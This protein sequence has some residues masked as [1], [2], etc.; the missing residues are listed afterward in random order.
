MIYPS[1]NQW[2]SYNQ[3]G[4][5]LDWWLK[6]RHWGVF[7]TNLR[8]DIPLVGMDHSPWSCGILFTGSYCAGGLSRQQLESCYRLQ[9]E[10]L[11]LFRQIPVARRFFTFCRV[12]YLMW[13]T[14]VCF[15]HIVVRM[16]LCK[17]CLVTT[18]VRMAG[19]LK[20]RGLIFSCSSKFWRV[21]FL[22]LLHY[23]RSFINLTNV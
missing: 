16:W 4:C 7:V 12:A 23:P 14:A 18:F 9:T 13:G 20:L 15:Y 10:F 1:P 3:P 8:P 11:I 19:L 17:S 5:W 22:T 2:P 6:E 21:L